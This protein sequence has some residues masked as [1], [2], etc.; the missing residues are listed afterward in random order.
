LYVNTPAIVRAAFDKCGTDAFRNRGPENVA[1]ITRHRCGEISSSS[2][3]KNAKL[4]AAVRNSATKHAR[5]DQREYK[6]PS[7][8]LADDTRFFAL[9]D[10]FVLEICG[11][12]HFN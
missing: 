9:G 7:R 8:Y 2:D 5:D 6:S 3:Y 12:I 1:R 11:E 10:P 4:N